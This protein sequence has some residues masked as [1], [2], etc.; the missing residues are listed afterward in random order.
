MKRHRPLANHA[1]GWAMIALGLVAGLVWYRTRTRLRQPGRH[2]KV[3]TRVLEAGAAI[4]QRLTPIQ[5]INLYLDRFHFQNG[6]LDRQVRTCHYCTV[7]NEDVI[8]C[9][10]FDKPEPAAR[11]IG[12]EY[13]ISERL[14][15]QLPEE[16]RA[17]WHSHAYEVEAGLLVAPGLPDPA[18][19]ELMDKLKS[20]YGKTWLTWDTARNPALPLGIPRVMMAFVEDGQIRPELLAE[21]DRLLEISTAQKRRQRQALS[22]TPLFKGADGWVT[23]E[24]LQ[25]ELARAG[26]TF[27]EPEE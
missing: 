11:L 14:F 26:M 21:R 7:L 25:L 22:E 1:P 12:L 20:T 6:H 4:L 5:Q 2:K 16:E 19:L 3:K 10:L 9:V 17:L 24:V 18:E 8:Q 27:A 13:I 23:G 15:Q